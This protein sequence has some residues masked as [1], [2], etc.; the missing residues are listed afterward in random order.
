MKLTSGR[1]RKVALPPAA[2]AL[3]A[4]RRVDYEDAFL[5]D[6]GPAQELSGEQWARVIL[7]G[8]P[9]VVRGA[10]RW[11]WLSLGLRLGSTQDD[12]RVLGWEVRRSTADHALLAARSPLGIDAELLLEPR[13]ARLLFATML[14]LK[15]PIAHAV[16][17]GITPGHQQ[18]VRHVLGMASPPA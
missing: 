5:V 16:W 12:Q 17:A 3:S 8:A 11:G 18:T 10:L 15:T 14:H 1:V 4:H 13:R 6:A 7:E 2:R 9:P